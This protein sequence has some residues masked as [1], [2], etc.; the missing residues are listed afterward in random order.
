[1][2]AD[3]SLELRPTATPLSKTLSAREA[4]AAAAASRGLGIRPGMGSVRPCRKRTRCSYVSRLLRSRLKL[5]T[6][7][8][9]LRWLSGALALSGEPPGVPHVFAVTVMRAARTTLRG[10][11]AFLVEGCDRLAVLDK[12][13]VF[14]AQVGMPP[15]P[16]EKCLDIL[17]ENNPIEA[18]MELAVGP[19]AEA[20][21]DPPARLMLETKTCSPGSANKFPGPPDENKIFNPWASI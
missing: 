6:L 17:G 1:M 18:A 10:G 13:L 15:T 3:R 14:V 8:R 20:G 11:C 16:M 21:A 5:A 12:G 4:A 9:K 7:W 19:P 2:E